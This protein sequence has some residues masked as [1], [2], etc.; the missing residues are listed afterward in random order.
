MTSINTFEDILQA[1]EQN[2]ALR[3]AMRRH[4]LTEELLQLPAQVSRLEELV[5]DIAAKL[6]E[7][8][9]VLARFMEQTNLAM[10]R[11]NERQDRLEADVAELK[12]DVAGLKEGQARLEQGQAKL[13]QGQ[14]RMSGQLGRL[15]GSDYEQKAARLVGRRL[16]QQ[17]GI[18]QAEILRAITVPGNT[19]LTSLLDRAIEAGAVSYEEADDLELADLVLRG[20]DAGETAVHV[21]AEVSL[22]I[23]DEDIR[24]AAR[25]AAILGRA[26]GGPTRPAVIGES[27]SGAGL[28]LADREQVAFIQMDSQQA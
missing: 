19:G 6:A 11:L 18:G 16:R 25:R 28:E 27:I 15:I 4:L 26:S 9:G 10:A 1:M 21:V 23:R 24:R 2:P 3:D 8:T 5:A 20:L 14:A 22:T 17:L 7:L 13:E 12:T